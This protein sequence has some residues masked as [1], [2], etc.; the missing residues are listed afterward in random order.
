MNIQENLIEQ[1]YQPIV[2]VAEPSEV[3]NPDEDPTLLPFRL[4]TVFAETYTL[5]LKTQSAH[6]GSKGTLAF[7]L[8]LLHERIYSELYAG[9]DD[10]AEMLRALDIIVPASFPQIMQY[11]KI[12]SLEVTTS[13]VSGLEMISLL[14]D[15]HKVLCQSIEEACDCAEE[16]PGAAN[17]LGALSQSCLSHIYLLGSLLK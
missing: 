15:D 13:T 3:T 11:S 14:L 8:H 2:E 9:I 16:Y 4:V 1:T 5:L 17:L 7:Q 10:I 6:W 12:Q